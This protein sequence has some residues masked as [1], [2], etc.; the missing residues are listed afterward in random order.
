MKKQ[1]WI[2]YK[3]HCIHKTHD[4]YDNIAEDIQSTFDTSNDELDIPLPKAKT[5]KVIGLTEDEC[6]RKFMTKLVELEAKNYSYLIDDTS[7]DKKAK[8]TKGC[9]I[10]KLK[11]QIYS[12]CLEAIQLDNNI[13]YMGKNKINTNSLKKI[14]NNL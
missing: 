9:V 7:E 6:G 5:K 3:F 12:N 14:I 11:S 4:I 8:V 2:V 1:N 10:K 13:N